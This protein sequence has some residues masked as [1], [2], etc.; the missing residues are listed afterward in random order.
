MRAR[1]LLDR[2]VPLYGPAT[3][4]AVY[5][6]FDEAWATIKP[7]VRSDGGDLDAARLKLAQALLAVTR[8][9][10]TDADKIKRL[11]LEILQLDD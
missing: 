10:D 2:S 4:K 3:M 8:D 5:E 9:G 1:Q 7:S 6:A 11:A